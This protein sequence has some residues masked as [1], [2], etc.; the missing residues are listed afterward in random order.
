MSNPAVCKVC[1][2]ALDEHAL[3]F[4][5]GVAHAAVYRDNRLVSC[6][7]L[8]AEADYMRGRLTTL[9]TTIGSLRWHAGRLRTMGR[10]WT[11]DDLV[12]HA[13][14]LRR[15]VTNLSRQFWHYYPWGRL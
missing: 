11:P 8:H 5:F 12:A 7:E 6:S 10:V 4:R 15:R 9:E 14:K 1:G 2:K 13:D 3:V